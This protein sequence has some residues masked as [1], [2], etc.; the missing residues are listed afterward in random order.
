[1]G[2]SDLTPAVR[3]ALIQAGVGTVH[4]LMERAD[5]SACAGTL[6]SALPSA[7]AVQDALVQIT[8]LRRRLKWDWNPS[9]SPDSYA[10]QLYE[11]VMS[12]LR[13]RLGGGSTPPEKNASSPAASP[14]A[15]RVLI[16]DEDG[17]RRAAIQAVLQNSV[18]HAYEVSSVEV[19]HAENGMQGWSAYELNTQAN[20]RYDLVVLGNRLSHVGAMPFARRIRKDER[21][22]K[23]NTQTPIVFLAEDRNLVFESEV[24]QIRGAVVIQAAEI[25]S[26]PEKLQK[27]V[28]AALRLTPKSPAAKTATPAW[29]STTATVRASAPASPYD[30]VK[31]VGRNLVD[32]AVDDAIRGFTPSKQHQEL[33]VAEAEDILA[34]AFLGEFM[35]RDA[36]VDDLVGLGLNRG[37]A[38]AVSR[39]VYG[40]PLASGMFSTRSDQPVVY[41]EA[42]YAQDLAD[43]GLVT[44]GGPKARYVQA[45]SAL[46]ALVGQ[47]E[48]GIAVAKGKSGTTYRVSFEPLGDVQQIA[49]IVSADAG[50]MEVY[51]FGSFKGR[52]S[53]PPPL[54]PSEITSLEQL[55]RVLNGMLEQSGGRR[56]Q[57]TLEPVA[58]GEGLVS[59]SVEGSATN[60][61]ILRHYVVNPATLRIPALLA[62]IE[63]GAKIRHVQLPNQWPAFRAQLP[64][65]LTPAEARIEQ[66][67]QALGTSLPAG[68]KESAHA[69]LAGAIELQS[70]GSLDEAARRALVGTLAGYL[71]SES[72]DQTAALALAGQAVDQAATPSAGQQGGA[73]GTTGLAIKRHQDSPVGRLS[74][75]DIKTRVAGVVASFSGGPHDVLAKQS[76]AVAKRLSAEFGI[77]VAL[78]GGVLEDLLS[79]SSDELVI[80]L[81]AD[82]VAEQLAARAPVA[83]AP[84][85]AAA[86][87]E[88]PANELET[89]FWL[90]LQSLMAKPGV[91]VT[92]NEYDQQALVTLTGSEAAFETQFAGLAKLAAPLHIES[93]YTWPD[94]FALQLTLI[95]QKSLAQRLVPAVHRALEQKSG[96]I[97]AEEIK[98]LADL[99]QAINAALSIG[100][101]RP[102]QVKFSAQPS[103]RLSLGEE[104]GFTR[105]SSPKGTRQIRYTVNPIHVDIQ[106]LLRDIDDHLVT[107]TL[108][109][110]E[111]RRVVEGEAWEALVLF[112]ITTPISSELPR[113]EPVTPPQPPQPAALASAIP[114]QRYEQVVLKSMT[115]GDALRQLP[116]VYRQSSGWGGWTVPKD[117]Y[118]L[119]FATGS[120]KQLLPDQHMNMKRQLPQGTRLI[121]KAVTIDD[122]STDGTPA[123]FGGFEQDPEHPDIIR[124]T[125]STAQYQFNLATKRYVT[126]TAGGQAGQRLIGGE[127]GHEPAVHT[128]A[129]ADPTL[130]Q[131]YAGATGRVMQEFARIA[132]G[133]GKE[134]AGR[135]D[136]SLVLPEGRGTLEVRGENR[137]APGKVALTFVGGSWIEIWADPERPRFQIFAESSSAE[138][139]AGLTDWAVEVIQ[140]MEIRANRQQEIARPFIQELPVRDAAIGRA[141]EEIR[142]V[143]D[144]MQ[145]RMP[146]GDT[147]LPLPDGKSLYVTGASEGELQLAFDY[148]RSTLKLLPKSGQMPARIR[149][150]AATAEERLRVLSWADALLKRS[151]VQARIRR[152]METYRTS[153]TLLRIDILALANRAE[154]DP[155]GYLATLLQEEFGVPFSWTDEERERLTLVEDDEVLASVLEELVTPRLPGA[156]ARKPRGTLQEGLATLLELAKDSSA[157]SGYNLNFS[158]TVK[159]FLAR[160][161]FKQL[162]VNYELKGLFDAGLLTRRRVPNASGKGAG[163]FIYEFSEN[164]RAALTRDPS[165]VERLLTLSELNVSSIHG[166]TRIASAHQAVAAALE[167][168]KPVNLPV[169]L[170]ERRMLLRHL[171]DYLD[172]AIGARGPAALPV[173]IVDYDYWKQEIQPWFFQSID[174]TNIRNLRHDL[175]EM[176]QAIQNAEGP[177]PRVEIAR[178]RR[179]MP[180][181]EALWL[182]GFRSVVKTDQ[183]NE[184]LPEDGYHVEVQAR[185]TGSFVR[186]SAEQ[187][188]NWQLKPND[189]LRLIHVEELSINGAATGQGGSAVTGKRGLSGPGPVLSE[190]DLS[191]GVTLE[192]VADRHD[193]PMGYIGLRG[194]GLAMPAIPRMVMATIPGG[195]G[196]MGQPAMYGFGAWALFETAER[197][198][199]GNRRPP[200]PEGPGHQPDDW[201]DLTQT[202]NVAPRPV[203]DEAIAKINRAYRDV[204]RKN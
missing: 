149:V 27:H 128:L 87:E 7:D 158:T 14:R 122:G 38:D 33:D 76:D 186:L 105:L 130:R 152:V 101:S 93:S 42:V 61:H 147:N 134:L 125:T 47:E 174:A 13:L 30:R 166:A 183:P 198:S 18:P 137:D 107:W 99:E 41:E 70:A 144:V 200:P 95:V 66:A 106:R 80:A 161:P 58:S 168:R 73:G 156:I 91:S 5:L 194:S 65:R 178:V 45:A 141:S 190:R 189:V 78:N 26:K 25:G 96:T 36:V 167:L 108:F 145:A 155:L 120:G 22:Q 50:E 173:A 9:S 6:E 133:Y 74:E 202:L 119:V 16:V 180:A 112:L 162:T 171:Q 84:S 81:L 172:C 140:Q 177:L 159:A 39:K 62:D 181:T 121:L 85:I 51:I 196:A 132:A 111:N 154:R 115:L 100:T 175:E 164:F 90:W 55:E 34:R 77:D 29:I 146:E 113:V 143:A 40:I 103:S 135:G 71:L 142:R 102:Y 21:D 44:G 118:V 68:T 82:L 182:L 104:F 28:A 150:E 43:A 83:P 131:A 170:Q 8:L 160:R 4:D 52:A 69:L 197:V 11:R 92:V 37:I 148:G 35:S 54:A 124:S 195:G 48:A 193:V 63:E 46:L 53:A 97:P 32:G 203:V 117:G 192:L 60:E 67:L 136:T 110:S 204:M 57:I 72:T 188:K 179:P 187:V 15:L 126:A 127:G 201:D 10:G 75:N 31:G 163:V 59:K 98:T 17:N 176:Q 157:P 20:K 89:T 64:E 24:K 169:N 109:D 86:S 184:A 151:D 56:M 19:S 199:G 129:I 94:T 23:T 123:P 139:Q 49:R 185:G 138:S 1:L 116:P 191:G 2:D 165:V 88:F 12:D 3:A 153:E 79:A 114:E